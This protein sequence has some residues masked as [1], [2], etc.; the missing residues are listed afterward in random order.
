MLNNK[1]GGKDSNDPHLF[2]P[3]MPEVD[4]VPDIE[5]VFNNARQVVSSQVSHHGTESNDRFLVLIT[6]GRML[7]QKPCP[8]AG[9]IRAAD[10]ASMEKLLPPTVKKMVAVIAY[11]ELDALSADLTKTIPFVGILMGFAYIGH[12]VWVFEGHSS[13]L[14]A[15]CKDADLLLVDRG[16]LPFLAENWAVT[17]IEAVHKNEI[18]I[19]DRATFKLL[20]LTEKKKEE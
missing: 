17:A 19:H 8:P 10:I 9:S 11:T 16:M 14:A 20:R 4:R 2:K 3:R 15:G 13:A 1:L 6:P 7:M 12:A 5:E 18:Y